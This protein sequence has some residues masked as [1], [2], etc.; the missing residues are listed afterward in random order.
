MLDLGGVVE[1]LPS[2]HVGIVGALGYRAPEV[3]L[4]ESYCCLIVGTAV[5][6]LQGCRGVEALTRLQLDVSSPNSTWQRV[7]FPLGWRLPENI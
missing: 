7:Y 3:S 5:P 2:G 6:Y 4:G 1:E